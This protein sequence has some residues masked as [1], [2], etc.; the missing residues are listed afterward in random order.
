LYYE[1]SLSKGTWE[2]PFGFFD[3]RGFRTIFR[4]VVFLVGVGLMRIDAAMAHWKKK[5]SALFAVRAPV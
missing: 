3:A 4:P 1:I 5:F 2:E